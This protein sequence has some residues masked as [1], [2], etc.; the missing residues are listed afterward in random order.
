MS[1]FFVS[2]ISVVQAS[3]DCVSSLKKEKVS[4]RYVYD[5]DTVQ[6]SDRRRVR[7]VGINTPELK[8][9]PAWSRAIARQ[10]TSVLQYWVSLHKEG[11]YLQ[12]E[13][14]AHDSYGRVLGYLVDSQ[15]V[16][17]DVALLEQGLAY[18]VS[19]APNLQKQKCHWVAEKIARSVPVGVWVHEPLRASKLSKKQL[20]FSMLQGLVTRQ[21]RFK[22]ADALVLDE[23]VV[24]MLRSAS[25]LPSLFGRNIQVRGWVQ[26]KA[27][28]YDGFS[29]AF[30][31][32]LNQASNIEVL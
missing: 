5:G 11:T 4:V 28:R 24:V 22:T 8:S 21:Y 16:G 6:L 17:P 26:A 14:E 12:I 29:A 27:F 2:A 25:R 7:L 23:K 20:G 31:L 9:G 15:G 30:T 32:Y 18:G 10:A 1:A 3:D 13:K 19:I